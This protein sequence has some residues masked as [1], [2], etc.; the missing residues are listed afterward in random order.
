MLAMRGGSPQLLP[1]VEK[2]AS[3]VERLEKGGDPRKIAAPKP[4][5][6]K[7]SLVPAGERGKEPWMDD[8]SMQ[9]GVGGDQAAM[10]GG[11]D[12]PR[13]RKRDPSPA[14]EV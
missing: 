8:V 12:K 6:S 5:T 7:V 11:L 3:K 4:A 2:P 1:G 10:Q 13:K 9:D 14:Q